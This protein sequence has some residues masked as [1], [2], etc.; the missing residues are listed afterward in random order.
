MPTKQLLP[1]GLPKP[2]QDANDLVDTEWDE[3]TWPSELP[4]SVPLDAQLLANGF[5]LGRFDAK[6]PSQ[7]TGVDAWRVEVP[8]IHNAFFVAGTVPSLN[9]LLE[10]MNTRSPVV[11]SI[12]MRALPQKGKRRGAQYCL[13]ND[14]KQD[15]TQRTIGALPAGFNKVEECFFGYTVVEQTMRRDPSNIC[16]AAIKFIEDGLVKAGAIKNDG[17][18]QVKGIRSQCIHRP[19]RDAG[20]F[21]VMSE[22]PMDEKDLTVMYEAWWK[23]SLVMEVA[24]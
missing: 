3:R 13:Y 22:K 12:I 17:W 10:A 4:E 19:G 2:R 1:L 8:L 23:A 21:V 14:I 5:D 7:V 18:K 11:R 15:W 20:I 6:V 9:E 16:S 24:K